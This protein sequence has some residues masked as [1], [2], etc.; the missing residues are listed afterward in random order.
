[1]AVSEGRIN[2]LVIVKIPNLRVFAFKH[3]CNSLL[4]LCLYYGDLL[5]RA[6]RDLTFF[7][8]K[9]EARLLW[10][11]ETIHL[12]IRESIG[13]VSLL[14]QTL[15]CGHSS[16]QHSKIKSFLQIQFLFRTGRRNIFKIASY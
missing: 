15:W 7:N 3:N 8:S 14:F 10:L 2:R 11:I 6:A 9:S 13:W 4:V 1:M 16:W 5:Q 12:L